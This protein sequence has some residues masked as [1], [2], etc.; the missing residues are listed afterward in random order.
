MLWFVCC[1]TCDVAKGKEPN[2]FFEIYFSFLFYFHLCLLCIC[3]CVVC[4][5]HLWR[6]KE[7]NY[8]VKKKNYLDLYLC[9]CICISMGFICIFIMCSFRRSPSVTYKILFWKILFKNI[10]LLHLWHGRGQKTTTKQNRSDLRS[11]IFI[12]RTVLSVRKLT[13]FAKEFS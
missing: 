10:H 4:L 11:V 1:Y 2:N 8:F 3:I 5:L 13:L 9:F 12:W 7:Q 6:S